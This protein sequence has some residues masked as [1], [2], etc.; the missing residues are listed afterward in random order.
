MLDNVDL[1]MKI[2]DA[3]KHAVVLRLYHDA[4]SAFR[5][6]V[7]KIFGNTLAENWK[8]LIE[9]FKVKYLALEISITTKVENK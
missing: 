6:I 7:A 3:D 9:D 8:C 4:Y 5:E 2:P 1:M